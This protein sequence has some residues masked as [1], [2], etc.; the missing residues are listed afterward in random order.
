M[1]GYKK[2]I[3]QEIKEYVALKN[4]IR[5]FKYKPTTSL[6]KSQSE[7]KNIG[8]IDHIPEE[9]NFDV[10]KEKKQED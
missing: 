8:K 2:K 5:K 1:V 6:K 4:Q 10:K 9:D 3:A 7:A